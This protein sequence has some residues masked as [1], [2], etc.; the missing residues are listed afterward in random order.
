M[1]FIQS[2]L[3]YIN[4]NMNQQY[5]GILLFS[6]ITSLFTGFYTTILDILKFIFKILFVS[7]LTID[8]TNPEG[9][10]VYD[11]V[12]FYF[13]KKMKDNRLFNITSTVETA[14]SLNKIWYNPSGN[15]QFPQIRFVPGTSWGILIDNGIFIINTLYGEV[16][17]NAYGNHKSVPKSVTIYKLF[18]IFYLM[19]GNFSWK[20]FIE[21]I[22]IHYEKSVMKYQRIYKNGDK[23]DNVWDGPLL[24]D[25]TKLN[26]GIFI[27][28]DEMKHLLEDI[29]YFLSDTAKKIYKEKGIH[30]CKRICVY[31]PP[32]TGKSNL[33]IRIAGEY[34]FPIYY[35]NC[36]NLADEN[37]INLFDRV[38]RGIIIIEEIDKCID[39][40]VRYD[41][42]NANSIL[43]EGD[44]SKTR[45][46]QYPR[47]VAW[48]KVLD[49]II[50][51]Q[52]I[53][54]MTTNNIEMIKKLNHGSLVRTERVDN[55]VYF[56][57]VTQTIVEDIISKYY[58]IKFKLSEI[59]D[60]K[61]TKITPSDLVNILKNK[62]TL[63]ENIEF[64]IM[65]LI[66][67]NI[68][69]ISNENIKE[70]EYFIHTLNDKYLEHMS[71][72]S[73]KC[74]AQLLNRNEVYT[75]DDCKKLFKSDENINKLLK[76]RE[77]SIIDEL[78]FK[79]IIKKEYSH[80][81]E[82]KQIPINTIKYFSD[83]FNKHNLKPSSTF[84]DDLSILLSELS[85]VE[86]DDI[87]LAINS[88]EFIEKLKENQ[89]IKMID[90]IKLKK[91]FNQFDSEDKD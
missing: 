48:H 21:K 9:C 18:P 58:G 56:G 27:I 80:E 91:I 66:N 24:I 13:S 8:T 89:Y 72:N 29:K 40:L 60:F 75:I 5:V 90:R 70:L 49:K 81:F 85:I 28:T 69:H 78:K 50:G 31:G 17:T 20:N 88:K 39:E 65:N 55:L 84:F 7:W 86:Y 37:I 34:D 41:R 62:D 19:L 2:V 44:P 11:W 22:K 57:Y 74:I 15:N 87:I 32:G 67:K 45:G 14:S 83:L 3:E 76:N 71:D 16:K 53:V 79:E 23:W 63:P 51:H 36:Q 77:I 46:G 12:I 38:Q 61:Q 64:K 35:L 33:A 10:E 6:V 68:K 59:I 82:I 52:V 4:I 54:Y 30:Y 25:R 42:N 43:K 1:Q 47:L 73:I 26:D